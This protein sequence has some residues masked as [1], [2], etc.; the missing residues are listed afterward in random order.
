MTWRGCL[1]TMS[2]PTTA[3]ASAATSTHRSMRLEPPTCAFSRAIVTPA[4]RVYIPT[5]A[6][7]RNAAGD[8]ARPVVREAAWLMSKSLRARS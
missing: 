1:L 6:Q 2:A 4:S 7:L 5:K 8:W 3:Y